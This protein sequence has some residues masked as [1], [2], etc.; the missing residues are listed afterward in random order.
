MKQIVYSIFT[1]KTN[2]LFSI[3]LHLQLIQSRYLQK[4]GTPYLVVSLNFKAEV[5]NNFGQLSRL[6]KLVMSK[7]FSWLCHAINEACLKWRL[8]YLVHMTKNFFL[9]K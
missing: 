4:I 9:Y 8:F 1:M 5:I 3:E 7:V 2:L 6:R